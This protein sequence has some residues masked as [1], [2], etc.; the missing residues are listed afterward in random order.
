[1]KNPGITVLFA[2]MLL[3]HSLAAE[4]RAEVK[5]GLGTP[6]SLETNGSYVWLKAFADSLQ[7]SGMEVVFYPNSALGNETERADQ[8]RIG[9]LE[10]NDTAFHEV[11][12]FSDLMLA[13]GLP[14][15]FDSYP[16]LDKA[17]TD[18]GALDLINGETVPQGLRIVDIAFVGRMYGVHNTKKP[19]YR[20][21]DM[22]DLRMRAM[23]GSQIKVMKTWGVKAT[24]VAFEEVSQA[25]QTGVVDGYLNPPQTALMFGHTRMLKYYADL[26]VGGSI[27]PMVVSEQWYQS[28][29][30]SQQAA[31][32][33]AV[34]SGRAANRT[35][36]GQQSSAELDLL[37]NAGVTV[38]EIGLEARGEWARRSR[39][40]YDQIVPGHVVDQILRI[41][42]EVR[43]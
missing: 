29:T 15:L 41:A 2:L 3:L 20:L 8:L 38:T 17:L 4:S 42:D 16:H 40:A 11:G 14:F 7:S 33:E 35:W 9:L 18:G 37:R 30:E 36:N 31:V 19:I 23:E 21:E 6:A 22:A 39:S 43:Q 34:E 1:M 5:I 28:L 27:R 26:K 10:V 24:Q 13:V 12:K 32:M 25:L